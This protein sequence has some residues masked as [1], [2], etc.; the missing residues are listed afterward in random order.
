MAEHAKTLFYFFPDSF[1]D[2]K[3]ERKKKKKR[4]RKR[5]KS[6]PSITP[7]RFSFHLSPDARTQ[8]QSV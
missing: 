7:P 1:A 5:N 2:K 8:A 6:H 4:K 3:K